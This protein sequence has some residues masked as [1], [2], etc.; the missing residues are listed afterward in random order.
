MEGGCFSVRVILTMD[1][2]PLKPYFQGVTSRIG[3]PVLRGEGF[4]VE[5]GGEDGEGVHGFIHA[6]SFDVGPREVAAVLI[7]HAFGILVGFEGDL[8]GA[9][10]GVGFFEEFAEGKAG[11][12]DDHGPGLD[13]A[14]PVDAFFGGGDL[15]E[16]VE[17]EG[18]GIGDE[19]GDFDF[20]AIGFEIGGGG[21]DAILI[22]AEFVEVVVVGDV[23]E[24]GF[25][26]IGEETGGGV[27]LGGRGC[28]DVGEIGSFGG[29]GWRRG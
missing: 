11:P 9:G 3:A 14:H 6:K 19:A 17:V 13:A 1:L 21:G 4:A 2:M 27:G 8:L 26:F 23:F 28:D 20:P 12:G 15:H 22:K 25:G 7:G 29:F 5:A 16:V 10:E 18:F 24:G